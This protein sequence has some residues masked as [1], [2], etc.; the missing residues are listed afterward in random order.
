[1]CVASCDS[2]VK[3][4]HIKSVIQA[5]YD[6]LPSPYKLNTKGNSG[7]PT[8]HLQHWSH[9]ADAQGRGIILENKKKHHTLM[10]H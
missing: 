8:V 4:Q 7:T 3:P 1:M 9:N 5:I 10:A 2:E 6:V